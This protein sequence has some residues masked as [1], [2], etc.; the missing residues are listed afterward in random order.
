MRNNNW[1]AEKEEVAAYD[2]RECDLQFNRVLKERAEIRISKEAR[3]RREQSEQKALDDLFDWWKPLKER[4]PNI[5]QEQ[6]G[7]M[8]EL[9]RRWVPAEE[10]AA[11]VLGIE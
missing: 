11:A 9:I 8:V 3:R 4:Y 5:T 1:E 7:R 10:A 6:K 2:W